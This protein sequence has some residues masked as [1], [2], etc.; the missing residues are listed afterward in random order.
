MRLAADLGELLQAK[1]TEFYRG[2]P[3]ADCTD[4][5]TRMRA[6]ELLAELLGRKKLDVNL[7]SDLPRV[8]MQYPD[9]PKEPAGNGG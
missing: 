8:V 4:N 9:D 7:I 6:V 2:R 5:G 3:V 1:K